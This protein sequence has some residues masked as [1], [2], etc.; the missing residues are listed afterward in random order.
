[1]SIN[2]ICCLSNNNAIGYRKELLFEIKEDLKRFQHLT[3]NQIV[4]MGRSTF[5]SIIE[6]NNKP[7]GNGR[8]NVVLSR[9][10]NYTS[11]YG[12]YVF[13]SVDKI[14]KH[15]KTMGECDKSVWILGGQSVF[16]A[17]LPHADNVYLT[18]VNK[19]VFDF[20]AEYPMGLQE[21]LG[22]IKTEEEEYHSDKYN[23][24]YKFTRYDKPPV[25]EEIGE[26]NDGGK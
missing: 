11:K 2:I 8:T 4:V 19:Y 12:E 10:E 7:L 6:R 23:C 20:D 18:H 22:F 1:M 25:A 5:E 14:L 21:N 13:N 15:C 26:E 17:F 3:K 24:S 16:E 9:D